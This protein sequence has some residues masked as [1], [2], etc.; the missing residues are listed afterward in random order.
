MKFFN[1]SSFLV[2]VLL[3]S[4]TS[5]YAQVKIG[6]QKASAPHPSAVLELSDSAKG[7]LMPRVSKEQMAGIKT[8]ANGLMVYNTSDDKIYVYRQ[9]VK[10][11]R[12]LIMAPLPAANMISPEDSSEW[13]YDTDSSRV[14]LRRGLLANDTVFYSPVLGKFIFADR[15]T[16]SN[17]LGQPDFNVDLL[18]GKWVFKSTASM[19]AD[20]LRSTPYTSSIVNEIDNAAFAA[21]G[22]H[23]GLLVATTKNPKSTQ[24]SSQVEGINVSSIHAGQDT[25][26]VLSGIDNTAT[27]NGNGYTEEVWGISNNARIS[28]NSRNDLLNMYG[29]RNTITRSGLATGMIRGNVYGYLGSLNGLSGKVDGTMYGIF[30]G[31]VQNGT[32]RRN[33]GIFTN[34]G[35]NRFGD[36]VLVTDNF[37]TFPRAVFDINSSSAMIMPNGTTAQRP[38][39]N[40]QGM[41]RYNSTTNNPEY[42]NGAGWLGFGSG[43]SEWLFNALTN[44][45]ELTRGLTL[46]DSVFYSTTNKHFI[47]SDRFTY[48]N[49]LGSDFNADLLGG[50]FVFKSTASK[51]SDSA[52]ASAYTSSIINEVD[53]ASN[54]FNDFHSGLLVATTVNPKSLQTSSQVQGINVSTIHA[55]QDTA[56]L[57]N[58]ITNTT[59]I[60]G[61]GYTETVFGLSNNV[62]MNSNS[63]NGAGTIF[64]MRNNITRLPGLPGVVNGNIY[65][66]FGAMNGF[67]GKLTGNMYGIFLNNVLDA[68]PG[69]NYAVYTNRGLNRFGDSVLVS[70]NFSTLP[71]AVFDINST[72]AMIMPN[73][74]TAQRP[75]TNIQ[76]MLRYNSTTNNPEFNNGAGWLGFAT[77]SS[78]WVFNALTNKVEL[79]RGL[80]LGDS[81]FYSTASKHFIFSDRYTYTNS[82]GSDFNADLLGGKFV[83]KS[84]ASKMTDSA[85]ASVYTSSIINEVDNASNTFTDSHSGLL[86]ATTVN[87][88]ATQVSSQVQGL[89]VSSIN[90]GQD[91]T[92]VLSGID[93]T[94]TVNGN[95]YTEEVWGINSNARIS[96]NSHNDVLN[97]YGMRNTVTRSAAATGTI[98]GNVYGYQGS[99]NGLSGKVDGTMY[100]IFLGNVQNGTTRRNYGI[101]TSRGLNRFGDSVLVTD[102]FSSFPRAVFDINSTSAMIMPNGTTAQRPATNVQGMLR[103]NSTGN[104]PEFNNG[105]T[106]KAINTDSS[107]WIFNNAASKVNMNRPL[108][109]GDSIFYSTENRHMV[110]GDRTTYTN[111]L[112]SDFTVDQLGGKFTF[113]ATASKMNDSASTATYTTSIVKEVDN[114]S[115]TFND[116]HS[117]LLVA[118]T[119]NPKST[120]TSS[121]VQ[122]ANFSTIHAGQNDVSLLSG[123]DNLTNING[124]GYTDQAQGFNNT[125]RMSANSRNNVGNMYGMRNT[126]SRLN[127]ATGR[128]T[129]NVYGYFGALGG[130]SGNVDGTMYGIFLSSVT[131]GT[132]R[133][134]YGIFTSAGLNRFGDSVLITN[135]GATLP[136]AVMDINATSAM[137]VPTGTTAN[138][139]AGVT[140]MV[141][142]NADNGGTLETY[143]GTEWSGILRNT[144]SIDIPNIIANGNITLTVTVPGATVGSVVYVSPSVPL[145][146]TIVIAW[147]RVS[148]ANTVQIS[149]NNVGAPAVNPAAQN[150]SIRV[151]Q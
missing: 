86:I 122:G 114:A 36:S 15:Y 51:M 133:R 91:T 58:G 125:V 52:T 28:S 101:F 40:I 77:G 104:N 34:R 78:E 49:S 90:A 143:N 118:T 72:S 132:T 108:L 70:D 117:G 42:N 38:A 134:N 115:N 79:T 7:F 35:L 66:Y 60:N 75:A 39:T 128:V 111:S 22:F 84:T 140:G 100:G 6:G 141:R 25:A 80:T 33:Y 5:L 24:V 94:A 105:V 76:G 119:V 109:Q 102:N 68:N 3:I 23:S 137:I 135:T 71:R 124:N 103:Y 59:T 99:L 144:Q 96:N 61:N 32:T 126:V 16:Y 67:G 130:F 93:N 13:V 37:S 2:I 12:E 149:F 110:F 145:P 120:Q 107:E 151:I 150:F 83:F 121:F 26:Y 17:S 113:K 65:G 44:K 48:T 10:E 57:L 136:R 74:S 4:G 69:K 45:V 89:N 138:R 81:V 1:L 127:T 95:G 97:M 27:V 62:R 46:G 56:F 142:Y 131:N 41:M 47:F 146:S 87:P 55:G 92:Y 85:S 106:W 9:S 14:Y 20:S 112:G 116:F 147:A 98:R 82:L 54:T 29:M 11:W 139:P 30:L 123:I 53:N 129:G 31:N 21:N 19:M 18:G 88:K 50:K 73:G 148:A 63:T 64:G 8:P 43:G